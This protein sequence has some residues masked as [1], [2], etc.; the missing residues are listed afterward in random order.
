LTRSLDAVFLVT[1]VYTVEIELED[2]VLA[3]ISFQPEG[4]QALLY[5]AL[6]VLLGGKEEILRDLLGD[7]GGAARDLAGLHTLDGNGGKTEQVDT[8]MI[9]EATVFDGD[10]GRGHIG[11]QFVN[12]D[13]L[14]AGLAAVRDQP[15]V[16]GDD[17]DVGRALRH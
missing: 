15:T 7:G 14:T 1:E 2:L 4:E 17:A 12:A 11:R 13:G 8:E 3:V 16:G 5:L 9:V 10:E 6:K